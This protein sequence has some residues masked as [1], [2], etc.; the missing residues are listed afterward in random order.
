MKEVF[1]TRELAWEVEPTPRAAAEGVVVRKEK[2][3]FCSALVSSL[4]DVAEA[5]AD[6][7]DRS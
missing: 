7:S 5:G 2:E 3:G 4:E 6:T 1:W